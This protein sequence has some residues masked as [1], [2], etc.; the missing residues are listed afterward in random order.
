MKKSIKIILLLGGL[1]W[2]IFSIAIIALAFNNVGDVVEEGSDK[3]GAAGAFGGAIAGVMLAVIVMM[4]SLIFIIRGVISI[5]AFVK[6][7][8]ND[9]PNKKKGILILIFANVIS[10]IL[11]LCDCKNNKQEIISND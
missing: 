4:I 11:I 3:S 10:G 2:L 1:F 6:Y 7:L 5:I 9:T 8:H